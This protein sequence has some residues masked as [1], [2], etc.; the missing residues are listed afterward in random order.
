LAIFFEKMCFFRLNRL[1]M[2]IFVKEKPKQ[3]Y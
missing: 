1:K 3:N 2:P